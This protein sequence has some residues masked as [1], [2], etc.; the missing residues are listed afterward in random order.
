VL[1]CGMPSTDWQLA[2][3]SY[4]EEGRGGRCQPK[5]VVSTILGWTQH[6]LHDP[7]VRQACTV[8]PVSASRHLGQ[9]I[10]KVLHR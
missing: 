3:W 9:A 5:Q 8:G 2:S 10:H 7:K 4:L 6:C 1:R